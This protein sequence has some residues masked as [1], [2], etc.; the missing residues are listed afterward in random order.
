MSY[1]EGLDTIFQNMDLAVRKVVSAENAQLKLAGKVV[2]EAVKNQAGLTD[3]T[4]DDLADLGHPYSTRFPDNN[5]PHGDDTLVHIQ[6]GLLQAN[7]EKAE[8][9]NDTVSQVAVGVSAS[10]VPY[11]TDLMEGGPKMRPRRFINRAFDISKP[12]VAEIL[13]GRMVE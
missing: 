3:H 4:L 7:I 5:G 2:H 13:S 9:L 12:I 6:S 8:D 1:V 11:I 10:K